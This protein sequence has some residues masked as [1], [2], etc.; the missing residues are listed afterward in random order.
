M[1]LKLVD[2][3]KKNYS[4]TAIICVV[5]LFLYG[6]SFFFG[7]T[8]LD[9]NALILNNLPFLENI[10]NIFGAFTHDVF[11]M[12]QSTTAFFRPILTISLMPE[13]IV[14]GS[15]PLFYHLVNVGIHLTAACL[16]YVLFTK[17]KYTKRISLFS[18]LIFVVHPVL[19]QAVAWIPGRNDSLLAVFVL[20]SFIFLIDFVATGKRILILISTVFFSLA[21]FT[22]ES[23][24]VLPML[25]IGY[26][27]IRNRLDKNTFLEF[28][29]GWLIAILLWLSL[30]IPAM[31]NPLPMSLHA[32]ISSFLENV[33]GTL[34]LL[35]KV[36]F[37]FNLS[38]FPI[39]QDTMFLWG[40]LASALIA[41]LLLFQV[42]TRQTSRHTY[43]MLLF[44]FVWFL[45]FLWPSFMKFDP[46]TPDFIEHRLYLPIIGL[47]IL[48][49]ESHVGRYL[50][51]MNRKIFIP[52]SLGLLLVL[53]GITFMY[54]NAFFDKI[55]FWKDATVN[56]PHSS[57]AQKNLGAMYFLDQ[58]YS[59]AEL[60]SKNALA[61]NP[62][63]PMA[64]NN[65]G[66]IYANLGQNQDAKK[67]YMLELATNPFYDNAHYNLGLLYYRMGDLKSARTE[68]EYTLK[69]NP[70]YY[71]AYQALQALTFEEN[72]TI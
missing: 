4:A 17:L 31:T 9:D 47:L 66:L 59:L 62:E 67:E 15:I 38:V 6:K 23:A 25:G 68:W 49:A 16:V 46:G 57:F 26:L 55:S 19:T 36:F 70:S 10:R 5:G 34:Q 30:R 35:G 1:L 60:H 58:N 14:G 56:S 13:A 12:A 45:A 11:F 8:Y 22:K 61:L 42:K 50:N 65:L 69:I 37:P 2:A 53:S 41:G 3:I 63:E 27:W 7:F 52:L 28:G 29:S 71:D 18:S 39:Q 48:L 32:G 33:P 64:H 43:L 21:L 72:K 24:I 20:A 51:E 40:Y 54:E 44:G